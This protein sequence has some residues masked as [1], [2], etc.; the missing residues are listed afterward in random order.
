MNEIHYLFAWSLMNLKLSFYS[1]VARTCLLESLHWLNSI[2][3]ALYE[4]F[5]FYYQNNHLARNSSVKTLIQKF[6]GFP[7]RVHI[8]I[9]KSHY[10]WNFDLDRVFIDVLDWDFEIVIFQV[11][12]STFR[13]TFLLCLHSYTDAA[14]ITTSLISFSAHFSVYL[15]IWLTLSLRSL[16]SCPRC[17]YSYY[18][19]KLWWD[20]S[21]ELQS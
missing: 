10:F 15:L 1:N 11:V 4:G 21:S 5:F 3:F 6:H 7:K 18:L 2:L 8:Q 13:S 16:P 19:S 14:T 12:D 17:S 9:C 20:A